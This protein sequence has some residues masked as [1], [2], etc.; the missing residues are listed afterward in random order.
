[1]RRA[2][3]GERIILVPGT[4]ERRKNLEVLI[5]AL[6][7]LPSARIVSVGPSTPYLDE[8]MRLAEH[9]GVGHRVEF[10]GYVP[11]AELLQLYANCALVAVPS[12]YEGFG[13]PAAQALCAGVPLIV[14]DRA[15]LPEVVQHSAPILNADDEEQWRDAIAAILDDPVEAQG[16]ADAQ[17]ASANVRFSWESCASH[18]VSVYEHAL[19]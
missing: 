14:S 15:S 8:C 13:Y 7:D 2:P 5:R 1:M 17:R 18:M 9:L 11:R 19:K 12:H 10:L 3:S 16:H 6:R 4:V